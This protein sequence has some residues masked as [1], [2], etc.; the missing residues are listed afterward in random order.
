MTRN[1]IEDPSPLRGVYEGD[2]KYGRA[3]ETVVVHGKDYQA[4]RDESGIAKNI[5][6]VSLPYQSRRDAD[7]WKKSGK[8]PKKN[9]VGSGEDILSN[10]AW[11]GR[12]EYKYGLIQN[13]SRIKQIRA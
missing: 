7:I 6:V 13:I 8:K 12:Y 11:L 10:I 9:E 2:L 4:N 5:P 3:C 1:S